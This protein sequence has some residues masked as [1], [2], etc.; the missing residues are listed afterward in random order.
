MEDVPTERETEDV[1]GDGQPARIPDDQREV[2]MTIGPLD[3]LPEH[4]R[5]QI[6]PDHPDPGAMKWQPDQPRPDPD[7]EA[8]LS[9]LQL[10]TKEVGDGR[11]RLRGQS[12]RL[13]VDLG[14][15]VERD[16]SSRAHDT[17]TR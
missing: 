8:W 1:V 13:V 12:S 6:D 10:A 2:K 16:R 9:R 4:R 14:S 11:A 5:R 17:G 3:Q 7:L 15:P